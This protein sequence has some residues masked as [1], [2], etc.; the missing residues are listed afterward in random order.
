M[1]MM[2]DD[3]REVIRSIRLRQAFNERLDRAI[4]AAGAV[5]LPLFDTEHGSN[6]LSG[7]DAELMHEIMFK[8]VMLRSVIIYRE[9]SARD[10]HERWLDARR[11]TRRRRPSA[12]S[13][14]SKSVFV[15]LSGFQ[16]LRAGRESKWRWRKKPRLRG[17]K[18]PS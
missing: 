16:H 5:L 6:V 18:G 8:L 17:M 4:D 13:A 3:S 2:R 12:P 7:R 9:V 11:R 14:D 1:E 15:G 10:V